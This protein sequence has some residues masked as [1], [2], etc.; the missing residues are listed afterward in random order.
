MNEK[1]VGEFAILGQ[2]FGVASHGRHLAFAASFRCAEFMSAL[3]RSGIIRV[4][5]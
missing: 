2:D 4:S 5:A 1:F 3:D